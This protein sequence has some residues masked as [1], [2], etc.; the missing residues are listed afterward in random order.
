[1][2]SILFSCFV[3]DLL[4][5]GFGIFEDCVD[6]SDYDDDFVLNGK[7]QKYASLNCH[8]MLVLGE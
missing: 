7:M 5:G 1:M 6:D 4:Y 2:W 8:V 3:L